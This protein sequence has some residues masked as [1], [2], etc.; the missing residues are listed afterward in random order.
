[1]DVKLAYDGE[2]LGAATVTYDLSLPEE[3]LPGWIQRD[4]PQQVESGYTRF[5]LMAPF[6][7]RQGGYRLRVKATLAWQ[8]GQTEIARDVVWTSMGGHETQT[9]NGLSYPDLMRTYRNGVVTG[10]NQK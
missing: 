3:G 4:P 1:V 7:T 2:A 9:D 8:G 5:S 10:T 6:L